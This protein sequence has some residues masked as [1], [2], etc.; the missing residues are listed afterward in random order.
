MAGV[1]L[2]STIA[3]PADD[4]SADAFADSDSAG[5][6]T[7]P[8]TPPPTPLQQWQAKFQLANCPLPEDS[9]VIRNQIESWRHSCNPLC[10][11]KGKCGKGE[12]SCEH[13]LPFEFRPTE[14]KS[15]A[16]PECGTSSLNRLCLIALFA[17][18]K[19]PPHCKLTTTDAVLY[20]QTRI[21]EGIHCWVSK[22]ESCGALYY[23]H[24]VDQGTWCGDF[25]FIECVGIYCYSSKRF[26]TLPLLWDWRAQMEHG[27]SPEGAIR[28]WASNPLFRLPRSQQSDRYHFHAF[29]S[30]L[31]QVGTHAVFF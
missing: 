22:C 9:L 30:H 14:R 27:L 20:T 11:S 23:P 1:N 17:D 6:T 16:N 12:A 18:S 24:P 10:P 2:L 21:I 19:E 15:C 5:D 28:A 26:Y 31:V 8:A 13:M 4:S 29:V 25:A 7:D 3:T